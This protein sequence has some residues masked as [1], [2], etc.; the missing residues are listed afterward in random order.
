MPLY[1]IVTR[2]FFGDKIMG[3]AYGAVFLISTLGMSLGS[4]AGGALY[5]HFGSYLRLY[6]GSGGIGL[7]AVVLALTF[8]RPPPLAGQAATASVAA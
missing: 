7:A 2:E 6:V 5:D 8:R 4:L 3:S 1:A